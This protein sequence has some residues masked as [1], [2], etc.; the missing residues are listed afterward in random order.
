M[1]PFGKAKN[2]IVSLDVRTKLLLLLALA[3]FITGGYSINKDWFKAYQ[4]ILTAIPFVLLSFERRFKIVLLY[5][6][7]FLISLLLKV[8]FLQKTAGLLNALLLINAGIFVRL[9]PGVLA[10]IYL[11]STTTVSEFVAGLQKMKVSEKI[12]IPLSV[13][14]RFFP[15][16]IEENKSISSAMKMRG[17]RFGGS[18]MTKIFEYRIIPVI[19][20]SV[21]IGEELSISAIT[22]GLGAPIK[23][24]NICEMK[25]SL[26]DL[27]ML[28]IVLGFPL[29]AY[30][31]L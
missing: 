24:T 15:T 5:G 22:R 3:I 9:I 29:L 8:V 25:I 12:I 23:R 21:K 18:Q 6:A 28:L 16:V 17:I 20:S 14:F 2:Q 26:Y 30:F 7:L 11:I 4:L 19:T 13:V 27:I 10:A 1:N 31:I